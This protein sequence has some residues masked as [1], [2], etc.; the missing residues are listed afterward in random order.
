MERPARGRLSTLDLLPPEAE[1]DVLWA[2]KELRLRKRLQ[3]DILEEFNLKLRLKGIPPIS[4][5]AFN[6]ASLRLMRMATRLEETREIAGVLAERFETGGGEDVTLL[7]GETIKVMVYEMLENAGRLKADGATAEMMMNAARALKSAEEARR[8]SADTK[9]LVEK[10]F[11]V[12]A[13]AAVEQV[14]RAK[15]LSAETVEAI[16]ANILGIREGAAA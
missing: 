8:I 6:R 2:H 10:E 15:G 9:R 4:K 12:K 16:K 14:A 11:K 3:Q 1:E 13:E 5:S 7:L